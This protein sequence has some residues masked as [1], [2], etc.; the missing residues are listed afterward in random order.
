MAK[1]LVAGR[2]NNQYKIRDQNWPSY[3]LNAMMIDYFTPSY[4]L[5]NL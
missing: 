2:K 5:L 1:E 4:L 3:K